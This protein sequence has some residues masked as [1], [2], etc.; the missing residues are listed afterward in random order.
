MNHV[1]HEVQ[2]PIWEGAILRGNRQTILNNRDTPQSSVQRLL[3]DRGAVWVVGSH[4]PKASLVTREVQMPHGK[5]QFW[6]IGAPIVTNAK[7]ITATL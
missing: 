7:A 3:T 4:G 6:W 1:L 2:M 5:G